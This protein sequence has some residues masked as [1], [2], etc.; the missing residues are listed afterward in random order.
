MEAGSRLGEGPENRV[1]ELVVVINTEQN[2]ALMAAQLET[3]E[4]AMVFAWL[5]R[6]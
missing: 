3:D 5:H 2:D 4:T 6:T 1:S